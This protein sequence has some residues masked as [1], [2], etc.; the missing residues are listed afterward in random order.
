MTDPIR[1]VLVDDQYVV[2]AG[3]RAILESADPDGG[4]PI[5]VV[6]EAGDG[7]H[8]VRTARREQAD[9]VLM[10]IRMP[11]TDGL[12]ATRR[13]AGPD[14][15]DPINVLVVTTFDLD[16]YVFQALRAGAAG[17][18]LK[19]LEP[20]ALVQ[21]VR[22]VARG[23][24]L[25]APAVTRRLIEEFARSAAP[26]SENPP[27]LEKLT[28]REHEIVALVAQGLS[29]HEI[30]DHLFLGAA[31]VKTHVGNVLLK[32]GLRDRVQ[33]VVYAYEHGIVTPGGVDPRR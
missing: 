32:L 15:E 22:V 29:N 11:G 27:G 10:D 8:G 26:P 13:L 24:G 17:F 12:E 3:F 21:A 2:R 25:V 6:G 23:E 9:V 16:E 7:D 4:D 14:V 5:E 1:T 30:A 33:A 28:E 20:E 19:D 31:T 18:L